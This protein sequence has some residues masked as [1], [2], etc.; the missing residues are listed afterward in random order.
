MTLVVFII[1]R[2]SFIL[3]NFISSSFQYISNGC[4]SLVVEFKT[5]ATFYKK[6]DQKTGVS[7]R[8]S[9]LGYR[10][11]EARVRFSPTA[12]LFKESVWRGF[13]SCFW[14]SFFLKRSV[15]FSTALYSFLNSSFRKQQK[16]LRRIY[17]VNP[18]RDSVECRES[19]SATRSTAANPPLVSP[20][21][22]PQVLEV[23]C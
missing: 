19:S 12:L 2:A 21:L 6:F 16:R 11:L 10:N 3:N 4:S 7:L 8:S 5:V 22:F 1:G 9:P 18:T 14:S 20:L 23:G 15:G 13:P 17:F